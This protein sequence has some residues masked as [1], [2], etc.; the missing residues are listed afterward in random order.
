MDIINVALANRKSMY[1]QIEFELKAKFIFGKWHGAFVS[2]GHN[3]NLHPCV[4][5]G[6]R[7]FT[8]LVTRCPVAQG[9]PFIEVCVRSK[10]S[11]RII[12]ISSFIIGKTRRQ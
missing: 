11:G 3:L 7:C 4:E 10:R 6:R 2:T 5:S 12:L 8:Q 1:L 9:A